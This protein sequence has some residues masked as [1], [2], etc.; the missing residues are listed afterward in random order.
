MDIW[1]KVELKIQ[2]LA[3]GISGK[4]MYILILREVGG[5]RKLPLLL[6]EREAQVVIDQMMQRT[7]GRLTLVDA[8]RKM[9]STYGIII[10]EVLIYATDNGTYKAKLSM[11][12]CGQLEQI[13]ISAV[14]AVIM[15]LTYRCPIFIDPQLL[16]SIPSKKAGN[17]VALPMSMLTIELLQEALQRAVENENYELASQLR[18]EIRRRQ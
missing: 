7:K 11:Y 15:A 1:N 9:T 18:D 2:E 14:D 13:T 17:L 12:Q 3:R 8:M 4:D 16:D 6:S 10:D 5:S